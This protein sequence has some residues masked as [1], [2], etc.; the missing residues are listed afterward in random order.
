MWIETQSE[1]EYVLDNVSPNYLAA[2][3]DVGHLEWAGAHTPELF[4]KYSDRITDLHVK[5]IDMAIAARTRTQPG[6]YFDVYEED[7]FLEPGRGG[8]DFAAILS[9]LGDEHEGWIIVEVDR[10]SMTPKASAEA[11]WGWVCN[12]AAADGL[13][14]SP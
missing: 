9:E 12:Q 8:I 2:A 14:V 10:T 1:I 7:F 11:S 5:D 13:G 3:F 6:P 4:R